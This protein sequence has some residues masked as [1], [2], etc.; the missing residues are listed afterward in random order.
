VIA[1]H[2][3]TFTF[4]GLAVAAVV[5][6]SS[7]A[8]SLRVN[9]D[10]YV[11]SIVALSVSAARRAEVSSPLTAAE[12]TL[13]RRATGALLW[14]TGQ[15]Q[16]FL[17]CEAS[18]LARRFTCAVV[19]DLG[20][21]NRVIMATKA[22]RLMPLVYPSVGKAARLR[23][24]TDA[25][26]VKAGIPTAH[27]GYAVV[28]MPA[29]V[30]AGLLAQ[31]ALLSLVAYVSH[32][33]RRVTHSSVAAEVSALLEGVRAA[34]KVAAVHALL[35]TGDG[36]SLPPLDVYT[37]NF[38]VYNTLDADGVLQPKEV[39]A[40]VQELRVL[41]HGGALATVTWLRARGK[42]ADILTKHNRMSALA[43]T[44][45]TGRFDVRLG[46]A[47]YLSKSSPIG[48]SSASLSS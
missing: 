41:Y 42:L 45:R 39:G 28:L 13:Y 21:A 4:T 19:A 38:S 37:G 40:A 27:T 2:C 36:F 7:G 15:P 43:D 35:A 34:T 12:L 6:M 16:P 5:D 8:L 11:E 46:D 44:I 20:V 32:R 18:M 47:D 10:E 25:F 9:Q 31:D 26:S 14:A 3:T 23:L 22:A 30:P 24:F 48:S 29:S 1:I 17:E 33:Q